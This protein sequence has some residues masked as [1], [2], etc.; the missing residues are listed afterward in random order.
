MNSGIKIGILG[1]SALCLYY[2]RGVSKVSVGLASFGIE[3]INLLGSITFQ[4]VFSISNP[5]RVSVSPDSLVG[6]LYINNVEVADINNTFNGSVAARSVTKAPISV[7]SSFSKIGDGIRSMIESGSLDN[8]TVSFDGK[9][10]IGVVS[11]PVSVTK[12]WS[13]IMG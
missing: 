8:M 7:V 2:L 10:K 9:L 13:E 1:V 12:Q 5:S 11:I 4:P 3:H 6:K